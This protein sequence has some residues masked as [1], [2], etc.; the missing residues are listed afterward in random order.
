MN[1]VRYSKTSDINSLESLI[2]ASF[3]LIVSYLNL[4]SNNYQKKKLRKQF[5]LQ[6]HQKNKMPRN[7]FN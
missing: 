2:Q 5:H 4:L 6:L 1:K 7:K 3:V